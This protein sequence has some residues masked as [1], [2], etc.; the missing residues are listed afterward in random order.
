MGIMKSIISVLVFVL[1]FVL[2]LA[3]CS[4]QAVEEEAPFILDNHTQIEVDQEAVL[5][6]MA[7]TQQQ[8]EIQ[9]KGRCPKT[10]QFEVAKNQSLAAANGI[11]TPD[12]HNPLVFIDP[13]QNLY[14]TLLVIRSEQLNL[15]FMS[16]QKS[17][18][19]PFLPS[20]EGDTY[21]LAN[22]FNQA[23]FVQEYVELCYKEKLY[24]SDSN[25]YQNPGEEVTDLFSQEIQKRSPDFA[26][27]PNLYPTREGLKTF[28]V[29]RV[30]YT[31]KEAEALLQKLQL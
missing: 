14:S 10:F 31:E 27:F 13:E 5:Q 7:W 19:I 30:K 4:R 29:Q 2:V 16:D 24:Q 23:T 26:I 18:V 15:D 25:N 3:A 11:I 1:V 22:K 8:P 12:G 28:L 6:A 21:E 9:E 17:H 20:T